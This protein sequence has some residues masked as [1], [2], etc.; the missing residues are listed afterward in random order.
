MNHDQPKTP[1]HPQV[2]KFM[3]DV[4]LAIK[5]GD[6]PST[7]MDDIYEENGQEIWESRHMKKG[8]G[9]DYRA[10]GL[11]LMRLR[12]GH[13]IVRGG[14]LCGVRCVEACWLENDKVVGYAACTLYGARAPKLSFL[15]TEMLETCAKIDEDAYEVCR[16]LCES[17]YLN[18]PF[19]DIGHTM[20]WLVEIQILEVHPTLL[21]MGVGSKMGRQFIDVLKRKHAIGCFFFKPFPSQ[22]TKGGDKFG[23][24]DPEV[25]HDAFLRDKSKLVESFERNLQAKPMP[26]MTDYMWVPGSPLE[27][28]KL[29]MVEGKWSFLFDA[30]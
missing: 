28:M 11:P 13:N 16:M 20:H 23:L 14:G 24:L 5:N 9:K 18:D 22:Y 1:R 26:G 7:T 29:G 19:S 12:L 2:Q 17:H 10:E 21:G 3:D 25:D 27:P 8:V 30:E 15:S 6:V 4:L